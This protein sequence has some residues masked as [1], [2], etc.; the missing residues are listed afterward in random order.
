[1]SDIR[2]WITSTYLKCDYVH[3]IRSVNRFNIYLSLHSKWISIPDYGFI[4][5]LLHGII[6]YIHFLLKLVVS[7]DRIGEHIEMKC[8]SKSCICGRRN[9]KTIGE[10][11][12]THTAISLRFKLILVVC[13]LLKPN[14]W[15][16]KR[17]RASYRIRLAG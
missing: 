16:L 12:H 15:E 7:V 1:M 5:F 6:R 2:N 9:R 10:K 4:G 17:K 13:V 3:Q 14:A 8:Q 11:T